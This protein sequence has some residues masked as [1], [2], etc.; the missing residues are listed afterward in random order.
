MSTTHWTLRSGLSRGASGAKPI[1]VDLWRR[2][3][4]S[5]GRHTAVM[6]MMKRT[7]EVLT[8][9]VASA[10][11]LWLWKLCSFRNGR[12]VMKILLSRI[13]SCVK[14]HI[15]PLLMS[16]LLGHRPSLWM[17]WGDWAMTHHADPPLVKFKSHLYYED[18]DNIQES[19][20]TLKPLPGS[21][22]Y[23]FKNGE[24]QGEA[25]I[26]IFQGC[27][28]PSVSLHKNVTVSVNFGPNFKYAP[29]SEYNYRPETILDGWSVVKTLCTLPANWLVS[30]QHSQALLPTLLALSSSQH[31]AVTI[32]AELSMQMLEEF[33]ESPEAQKLKLVQVIK[34]GRA[35]K[36]TK[37]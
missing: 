33:M 36:T 7:F 8:G 21:K 16:P 32:S 31:A 28:Y 4:L 15:K 19:L 20:N 17:E 23:Y 12:R 27:Y 25:F 29:S 11:G 13:P 37:K 9:A 10:F 3:I 2:P 24:C 1:G 35:K 22:I 14:R 6:I 5:S 18:K 34:Q 30:P 26:D